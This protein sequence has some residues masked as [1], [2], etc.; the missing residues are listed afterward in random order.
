[1]PHHAARR[2]DVERM[3]LS[4]VQL[5]SREALE[6][7]ALA[8]VDIDDLDVVPGLDEVGLCRRRAHAKV[9]N[10]VGKRIRQIPGRLTQAHCRAP[11]VDGQRRRSRL[12]VR[13]HVGPW[14]G[15]D[16]PA[17]ALDGQLDIALRRRCRVEEAERARRG[18]VDATDLQRLAQPLQAAVLTG[19]QRLQ[20]RG[21]RVRTM[22]DDAGVDAARRVGHD[23]LADLAALVIRHGDAVA[24]RNV[25]QH[26]SG[27]ADG[28]ALG[29]GGQG[30][31]AGTDD[32]ARLRRSTA[33]GRV[34]RV[35]HRYL[36]AEP[37][38][39][40]FVGYAV[41]DNL[42]WDTSVQSNPS[43]AGSIRSTRPSARAANRV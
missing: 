39:S 40:R 16:E 26:R 19:Q 27:A 1:M 38:L 41:I 10:R 11:Y 3:L 4:L 2:G 5:A 34:D 14:R 31:S 20:T 21:I 29:A 8:S 15:D 30:Q 33:D 28:V 23:D 43:S 35:Q 12:A 32:A 22:A 36:L 24:G 18:E 7:G 37:G 17:A 9:E 6:I 25:D 42:C 13:R